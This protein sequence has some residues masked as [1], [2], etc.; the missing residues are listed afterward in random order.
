M[1][2]TVP[3]AILGHFGRLGLPGRPG[4]RACGQGGQAGPWR[5]G[6]RSVRSGQG[7]PLRVGRQAQLFRRRQFLAGDE[8]GGRRS[9]RQPGTPPPGVGRS[10][11]T[12]RSQFPGD[13]LF[14]RPQYRTLPDCPRLDGIPRRVQHRVLDGL[15]YFLAEMGKRDMKAVMVLNNFWQWSGGMGQYVSWHENRPSHIRATTTSS[16]NT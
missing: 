2:K 14:R 13:G 3:I 10:A 1:R 15:D 9:Q 6:C 4:G 12:G 7:W 16:W 5:S 8:P 11:K